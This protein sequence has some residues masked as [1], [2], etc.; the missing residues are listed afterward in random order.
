MDRKTLYCV[1]VSPHVCI[2]MVTTAFSLLELFALRL[3]H[4]DPGNLLVTRSDSVPCT[5]LESQMR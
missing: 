5:I 3:E 2:Y 1:Y 4:C